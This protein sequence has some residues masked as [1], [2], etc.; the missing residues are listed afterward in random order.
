MDA[1]AVKRRSR[2]PTIYYLRQHAQRRIPKFG[3]DATDGG[4]GADGGIA[5]NA[6]ALDAIELM[7]RYGVDDG[8]CHMEI[9][10]FGRRYAAPFGIAPMGMPGVVWP[11]AEKY[12]AKAARR[13][14]IPYT[15]G[16]VASSTIEELAELAGD[17]LWFQLYR[18]AQEDHRHGFDL[19]RRAQVAGAHVLVITMDV[20]LRT[21]R[22]REQR[23]G[24][25]LPF[26]LD[27]R[28]VWDLITHPVW[29]VA[30]REHGLAR[31]ANYEPYV[32][33][34][35]PEQLTAF[36]QRTDQLGGGSFSWDEIARYRDLWRGPLVLKGIMHPGDAAKAVALGV[37]GI[38]V[39]NHGGRQV[40]GLPASVDVLPAIVAEVG[41]RATV[42][43]DSGVRSGLDVV[44]ALALGA[45]AAFVGKA[46]LYGLGAL[47]GEGPDHV[48]ELLKEEV[49]DTMRQVGIN[50]IAQ[51]RTIGLRHPGVW[52][53]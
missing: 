51:A 9:E 26:R 42:L 40:E 15:A 7:P 5:R 16:T 22:P 49:R 8:S 44:R 36:S 14:R 1:R 33:D 3:F 39:S 45:K 2:F 29:L 23:R 27:V 38:Q 50:S 17:M 18:I 10:L 21:K 53:A 41:E 4:A 47:G 52:Q 13:A 30:Y 12:L 46:F 19:V 32:D 11:G 20:P 37:D 31:F 35:T 43:F 48:I 25:V 28:I 34:A 6:A 24:L